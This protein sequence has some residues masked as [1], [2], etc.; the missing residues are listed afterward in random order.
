MGLKGRA[1]AAEKEAT[2]VSTEPDQATKKACLQATPKKWN[3]MM[4]K[5]TRA[6]QVMTDLAAME[7]M[8]ITDSPTVH[9]T[10]VTMNLD[11]KF[12][13]LDVSD[14]FYQAESICGIQAWSAT[15]R[16]QE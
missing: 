2:E 9:M 16:H 15:K 10:G 13:L 6:K 12:E 14:I 3:E 8:D 11:E 1:T 5:W 4:K 7:E